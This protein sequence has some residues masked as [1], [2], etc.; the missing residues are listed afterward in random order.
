[1]PGSQHRQQVA[2]FF[3]DVNGS[4]LTYDPS[5]AKL[6]FVV[7]IQHG[8]RSSLFISRMQSPAFGL[9]QIKEFSQLFIEK[10][11]EVCLSIRVFHVV[12]VLLV[13]GRPDSR[14]SSSSRT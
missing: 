2:C 9:P 5:S 6:W 10:A 4:K 7:T 8:F 1:M 14:N 11:N 13:P 3:H 12:E